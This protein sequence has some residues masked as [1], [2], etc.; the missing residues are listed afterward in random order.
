MLAV[1]YSETLGSIY[2]PIQHCVTQCGKLVNNYLTVQE[3]SMHFRQCVII[4]F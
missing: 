4:V 1:S 2:Q 3:I